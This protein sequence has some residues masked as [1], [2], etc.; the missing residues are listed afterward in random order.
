MSKKA[1]KQEEDYS[2]FIKIGVVMLIAIIV[3]AIILNNAFI[4]LMF[5]F[6]TGYFVFKKEDEI[7]EFWVKMT[8]DN[9]SYG[10][11]E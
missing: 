4:A 11:K 1:R 6:G 10:E 7:K 8:T 5:G 3:F 9:N 2:T